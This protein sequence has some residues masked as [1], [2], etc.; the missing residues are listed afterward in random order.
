MRT[1]VWKIFVSFWIVQALFFSMVAILYGTFRGQPPGLYAAT[2]VVAFCE[3]N[4]VQTYER[5]GSAALDA[6]LSDLQLSSGI[7]MFIVD[8]R[9]NELSTKPIP[10]EQMVL[11]KRVLQNGKP[12][13]LDGSPGLIMAEPIVRSVRD[14]YA[15]AVI[16]PRGIPGPERSVAHL[17]RDLALGI[18]ISGIV[19]FMLARYLTAPISR[20]R[21]AA[22]QISKGNLAARAGKPTDKRGDE[23]GHLVGDFDRMAAQLE[24][25]VHAQKRLISDVSHELRSPLTRMNLALELIR[26]VDHPGVATAIERLERETDRLNV[27]IGKLLVLSRFEA[28]GQIVEK[29]DLPLQDLLRE[30]VTDADY[31]ARNLQRRVVLREVEPCQ[32]YG[33]AEMLRSAFEN[34]IRNAIRHTA[35]GS[36]IDVLLSIRTAREGSVAQIKVRDHGPGVPSIS[37]EDL[38]RPFYRLDDS[39]ERKTGGVGLGLAIAKQAVVLHGGEVRAV[40]VPGGGLEVQFTLPVVFSSQSVSKL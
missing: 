28:E 3:R 9:G 7:Q 10:R 37:L 16:L 2:G 8:F 15:V 13:Y 26:K 24:S 12:E 40:N 5:S 31:E 33:N 25:L 34:V 18:L 6:Y 32:V 39:R 14:G 19:C 29:A 30:V 35:I 23:I 36:D 20:L 17:L 38:F 22:Q 21:V 11:L 4:A 27:M 1:L